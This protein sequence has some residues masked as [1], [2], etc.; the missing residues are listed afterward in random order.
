MPDDVGGDA[1]DVV[2]WVRALLNGNYDRS[3]CPSHD[4]VAVI[5]G[6]GVTERC[7]RKSGSESTD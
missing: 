2:N 7:S 6:L 1:N 4:P 3:R 5:L